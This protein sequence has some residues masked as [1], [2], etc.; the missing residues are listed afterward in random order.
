VYGCLGSWSPPSP[1]AWLSAR[2][3]CRRP[4]QPAVALT[5]NVE[6][7]SAPARAPM[8]PSRRFPNS[9]RMARSARRAG[10]PSLLGPMIMAGLLRC[11][12]A[13]SGTASH[14]TPSLGPFLRLSCPRRRLCMGLCLN[15]RL[16]PSSCLPSSTPHRPSTCLSPASPPSPRQSWRRRLPR[17]RP[18]RVSSS[19]RRGATSSGAMEWGRLTCGSG[20]RTHRRCLPPRRPH[21]PASRPRGKPA[22][23]PH[24]RR[25]GGPTR[26]ARPS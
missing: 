13:T 19:T 22:R 26:K 21:P 15:P 7:T 24:R 25:I 2:F 18:C 17:N 16:Q 5:F 6:S 9:G 12:D 3:S 4:R 23:R 10:S 20:S 11:I 14:A 1:C 8:A